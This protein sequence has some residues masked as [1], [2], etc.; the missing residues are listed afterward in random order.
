MA[1]DINNRVFLVF[2]KHSLS[3]SKIYIIKYERKQEI[4][5]VNV[6]LVLKVP[7]IARCNTKSS[8]QLLCKLVNITLKQK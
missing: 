8:E 6:C 2:E 3:N 7:S 4:I 1:L 5:S